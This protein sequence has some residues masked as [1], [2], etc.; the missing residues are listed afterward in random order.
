M[1]IDKLVNQLIL[2]EDEK[3]KPYRDSVGK[4]TIGVGR[5]LDD[6]GISSAESK[7]M[8]SND[9]DRTVNELDKH[10]V[11][12]RVLDD[13]RQ[14]VV[15]NMCFNLGVHSLLGFT[16]MLKALEDKNYEEAARQME[17]SLWAKQ[18]NIRATRLVY[19]M[20]SGQDIE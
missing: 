3:L 20:R 15:A 4:L 19:M 7:F 2:D 17:S 8:L 16:H 11:W 13:V 14:R 12:W 18:V 1:D 6:V 10:L 9:I 5:N